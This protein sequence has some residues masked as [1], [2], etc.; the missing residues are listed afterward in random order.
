MNERIMQFRIGM[1][2]IV[3]GLVLTMMVVWFEAPALIRQ[4]QYV[5]VFFPEAP[6]IN[7]GIPV[8]KSGVRIGEVFSF[9]FTDHNARQEG[10]LVTLSIDPKYSVREGS[11]PKLSRALIGDVSI[12]MLPGEGSGPMKTF[13][14]PSEAQK[15]PNWHDGLV[16]TDPFVLLSGATRIFDQAETTLGS[17]EKA[18]TG[19]AEI[20]KKA[21]NVDEFITTARDAFKSFDALAGDVKRVVEENEADI[22]P[23]V[24]ALRSVAQKVDGM[25]SGENREKIEKSLGQLQN[26]FIRLDRILEEVEPLTRDLSA[27]PGTPTQTNI[28]QSLTRLNRM[29]YE[30]SLLTSQLADAQ[31]K[32]NKNG[33]LQMLV[34]DPQL[35]NEVRAL[36]RTAD[37]TMSE[38]RTVIAYLK[39]FAEKIAR[40]PAVIGEGVLKGR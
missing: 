40:N 21:E 26:S 17:I 28:G 35:Y 8:R 29:T 24:T 20:T 7:E 15:E 33:T 18:A 10:V 3:A 6:G 2:V 4:R 1:F 12:D 11:V 16:A 23:T 36:S 19:L 5:S 9:Q 39:Q 13:S 27:G 22:K 38:A 31:G 37:T 34:T 30:L 14:N 32:L 25:L